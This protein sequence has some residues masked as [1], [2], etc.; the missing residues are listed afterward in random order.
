VSQEQ[1]LF[2][3]YLA[4]NNYFLNGSS[5][6]RKLDQQPEQSNET[7]TTKRALSFDQF[8]ST[9]FTIPSLFDSDQNSNE[10]LMTSQH[11]LLNLSDLENDVATSHAWIYINPSRKETDMADT[12][13][14]NDIVSLMMN[15]EQQR[16]V[17][18]DRDEI[19]LGDR[20]SGEWRQILEKRQRWARAH[21][22][23]RVEDHVDLSAYLNE[24]EVNVDCF[25]IDT[26]DETE[27]GMHQM[28][29]FATARQAV[30]VRQ[31]HA[32][33]AE[34][35]LLRKQRSMR[36]L[37]SK[38][39][40]SVN[41]DL[42]PEFVMP[43]SQYQYQPFYD[44]ST[45][46]ENNLVYQNSGDLVDPNG[47][48]YYNELLRNEILKSC[49]SD[50]SRRRGRGRFDNHALSAEFNNNDD[51]DDEDEDD[52]RE[53]GTATADN[54]TDRTLLLN[55]DTTVTHATA[56]ETGNGDLEN[57]DYIMYGNQNLDG[58]GDFYYE[59]NDGHVYE[60]MGDEQLSGGET[61]YYD[62]DY[63]DVYYIDGL[64]EEEAL[65]LLREESELYALQMAQAAK[66][67]LLPSNNCNTVDT[68]CKFFL[69]N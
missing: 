21:A 50:R 56:M 46:D 16:L 34:Q 28:L 49:G 12:V 23:C 48:S 62:E 26:D 64:S 60:M 31:H 52:E 63:E 29:K 44:L 27:F 51:D 5:G 55:G 37:T 22:E 33:L 3:Q 65:H 11:E 66:L 1:L 32:Y 8:D 9:D 59:C 35:Q 20:E 45:S 13:S 18:L 30:N 36:Q 42:I 17:E 41:V 43:Q 24:I 38:H 61:A 4:E 2:L 69:I 15:V 6:S 10:T 54:S 39:V 25:M 47:D 14:E 53:G 58:G 67:G 68:D 57:G 19:A 40:F 7:G